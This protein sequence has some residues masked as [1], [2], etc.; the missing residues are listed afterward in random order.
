M[1]VTNPVVRDIRSGQF[2]RVYLLYGEEG[3][4][5]RYYR[6]RLKDALVDPDNDINLNVYKGEDI[7]IRGV[8]DQADTMPF[9]AQHRLIII[10]DSGL[11]S[12]GESPLADYIP[13]IPEETVIIF[14][15][16]KVDKRSR[17]FKACTEHGTAFEC[18]Y[19][20][21][22]EMMNW[23]L[24]RLEMKGRRIQR[25]AMDLFMRC[26]GNDM[27][28]AENEID[29]LVAY[30]WGRE[31]ISADDVLAVCSI[32]LEEK[33][34]K[35]IDA[36]I[37]KDTKRAMRY[38]HDLSGLKTPPLKILAAM[39]SQFTRLL[40]IRDLREQGYDRAEIISRTGLKS[41]IVNN[42]LSL[43]EN[44]PLGSLKKGVMICA[45]A[46]ESIKRGKLGPE[47]AVEIAISECCR[48]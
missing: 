4:L 44:I 32:R 43:T 18:K 33:V 26:I 12:T 13:R 27:D 31:G 5:R 11:F 29:K 17:L 47:V 48:I 30:T 42:A 20:K 7:D 41:F 3:Y 35:M 25:D 2:T 37:A 24:R 16:E 45:E 9:F 46:D 34:F 22:G 38:Y 8:I 19:L 6:N 28:G 36:I 1:A 21:E 10:E 14:S 40:Q 39:G 23:V 15:E